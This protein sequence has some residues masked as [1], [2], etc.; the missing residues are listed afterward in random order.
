MVE[1]MSSV[2]NALG[3]VSSGCE[4]LYRPEEGVGAP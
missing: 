1:C 4:C 2:C 3:S